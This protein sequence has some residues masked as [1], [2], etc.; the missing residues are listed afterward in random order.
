MGVAGALMIAGGV[1]ALAWI[2]NPEHVP[3]SEQE[4]AAAA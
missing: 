3:V 2:Q 1:V 4:A